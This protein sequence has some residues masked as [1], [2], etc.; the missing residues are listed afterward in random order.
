MNNATTT[1]ISN[2]IITYIGNAT[3]TCIGNVTNIYTY[4]YLY[5]RSFSGSSQIC[6]PTVQ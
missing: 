5:I 2:V 3:T 1:Y 4:V 6:L